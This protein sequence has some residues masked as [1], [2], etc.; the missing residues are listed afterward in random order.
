MIVQRYDECKK[1]GNMAEFSEFLK[2]YISDIM[3][4]Y[5]VEEVSNESQAEQVQTEES[6]V[7]KVSKSEIESER[8]PEEIKV[9]QKKKDKNKNYENKSHINDIK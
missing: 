9:E 7:E 1:N 5:E 2:G 6:K 4:K 8:P 3:K